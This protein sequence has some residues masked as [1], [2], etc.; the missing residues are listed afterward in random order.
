MAVTW[1]ARGLGVPD[2]LSQGLTARAYLYTDRPAYRP[3]QQVAV[4]GVIRE[5]QGGQYA[6]LPRAE[7]RFEVTDSRGRQIVAR[8]VTLSDFGTFH[9]TLPL[10][11]GAPV[12]TYRLRLY[13]PG[14]S[15]FAGSFE[16]QSYQLEPI[17][18]ELRPQA[19]G[20]LPGRDRRG[21]HRREVPV[22]RTGREPADRGHTSR[23]ARRQC[24]DR[25]NGQISCDLL[26]RRLCRGASRCGWSLGCPRTTSRPRRPSCS[27]FGASTSAFI[28][29]ATCFSTV[30][31]FRFRLAPAMP[32]ASPRPSVSSA[33]VIKMVNQAGRITER[34]AQR[35]TVETDAKTGQGTVT[36]RIDD[37]QGGNYV[38]R[39][40]GIDR[41]NNAIVADRAIY[42][43]GKQDETKLRI[44]AERQHYKV[45][46]EAS[47]NLHSRGRAGT[48]LLTWEADRILTYKLVALSD[49]DNPIGW[50]IDGAQFPNFTLTAARMWENKFDEA[51]LDI[52]VERDL[53]VTV[54]PVKPL[55]GPGDEVQLEVTTVD[56]LGRP[57]SAEISIAM[58]D[59]SLLRLY[60]DRLPPIGA[61]FYNQT[62]H[63]SLLHRGHEHVPLRAGNRRGGTG[64][65]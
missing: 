36:F 6:N 15:D 52:E 9:E 19:D 48:A 45:G 43:S 13:Q 47:V 53:Q 57:A 33:A 49:G 38:L 60:G 59:R 50:A 12:G 21:R 18:L 17:E 35:K 10:D 62:A 32:A 28:P 58:I 63:R 8:T 1:R 7:Y 29:A 34:E 42:V 37:A 14:K 44:L 61:F 25:R 20:L 56:Q 3:G 39:V 46:E 27:R 30:N 41:F 16:V 2:K 26:H 24:H 23:P 54:A 55:V 51:K 5:V 22:R 40:A 65:R 11:R 31:P 64:R 4:R